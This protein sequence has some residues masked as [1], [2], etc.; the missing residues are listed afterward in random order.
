MAA[1]RTHLLYL[2]TLAALANLLPAAADVVPEPTEPLKDYRGRGVIQIDIPPATVA[3]GDGTKVVDQG[4]NLLG[5][6]GQAYVWPD[7]TLVGL[8]VLGSRQ[9]FRTVGRLGV[10]QQWSSGSGYIIER[11]YKNLAKDGLSPLMGVQL[12][13]STYARL[14][15]EVKTAKVL[16]EEDFDALTKAGEARIKELRGLR[17]SL[18][19]M[20]NP[21][22]I[23]KFNTIS[24]E[25]ARIRDDINQLALRRKHPC[26]VVEVQNADLMTNLLAAGLMGPRVKER[27]EKGKTTFWVTKAQGL[28]IRMETADASGRVSLYF[29]FTDL[30]IN[31]GIARDELTIG[32]PP[33]TRLLPV[34]ADV[35]ERDW[36]GRMEDD[37]H[38]LIKKYEE[39]RVNR[40]QPAAA[41]QAPPKRGKKRK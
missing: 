40:G 7:T 30:K 6:I 11:T 5:T 32:A 4:V 1:P 19:P 12:S 37:V 33:G 14:L 27:F 21:E 36:E 2:V 8:E 3:V 39:A 9:L 10:E 18:T 20:T 13:M 26:W 25:M 28:P 22:D 38:E 17:D 15:R 24:G 41:Q 16:P 31:A 34:V 35:R 29:S 23:P